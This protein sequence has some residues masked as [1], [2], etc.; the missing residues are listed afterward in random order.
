MLRVRIA[1]QDMA[2]DAGAFDLNIF[3]ESSTAGC[4]LYLALHAGVVNQRPPQSQS[5]LPTQMLSCTTSEAYAT[6]ERTPHIQAAL[7]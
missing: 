7:C 5:W 1:P 3:L 4:F 6:D 2:T